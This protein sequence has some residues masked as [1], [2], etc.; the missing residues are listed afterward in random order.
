MPLNRKDF[1]EIEFTGKVKGGEV[2]DSNTRENLEKMHEGHNHPIE[3]KP[4]IFCLGE[5]MFLDAV[6]EFFIGKPDKPETYEIELKPEQAFGKRDPALVK[7]IPL[8]VFK[9]H[10]TN[11]VPGTMLNFDGR[12]GKS[13]TVSGG[14]VMIDFNNPLAGKTVIYNIAVKRKIADINEKISAVNEFLFKRDFKFTV[15]GKKLL[16]KIEKKEKDMKKIMEMFTE[17]FKEILDM[18]LEVLEMPEKE[19]TSGTDGSEKK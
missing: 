19:E 5:H 13:L 15:D 11:P 12:I 2:F 18:D 6:D 16:I 8:R 14:R 17:K 4:F 10:G 7:M 1:I 9:E 3:A